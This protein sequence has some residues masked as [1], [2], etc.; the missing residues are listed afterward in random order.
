MADVF[1]QALNG[2]LLYK[3]H[4]CVYRTLLIGRLSEASDSDLYATPTTWPRALCPHWEAGRGGGG[5][6]V[7]WQVEVGVQLRQVRGDRSRGLFDGHKIGY[8][9]SNCG[10]DERGFSCRARESWVGN[11]GRV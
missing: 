5:R 8:A 3:G 4:L 1:K 9:D 11:S 6:A 7:G 2:R 10:V